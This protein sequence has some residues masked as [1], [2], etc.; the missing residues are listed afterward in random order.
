MECSSISLGLCYKASGNIWHQWKPDRRT[1]HCHQ[2]NCPYFKNHTVGYKVH[3][4]GVLSYHLSIWPRDWS[5]WI[6]WETSPS[7]FWVSRKDT[8]L[9]FQISDPQN[10]AVQSLVHHHF[11]IF[12]RLSCSIFHCTCKGSIVIM[13]TF[14]QIWVYTPSFYSL[15]DRESICTYV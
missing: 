6:Y 12:I 10:S 9:T 13:P 15:F 1:I 8:S 14:T 11:Q 3:Y 2:E 4:F 7:L 5:H